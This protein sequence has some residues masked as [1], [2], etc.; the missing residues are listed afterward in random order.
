MT[1]KQQKFID[2][3]KEFVPLTVLQAL[4]DHPKAWYID[5]DGLHYRNKETEDDRKRD[6]FCRY[7]PGGSK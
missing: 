5:R 2:R 6:N 1:R 3:M 7:I 4:I